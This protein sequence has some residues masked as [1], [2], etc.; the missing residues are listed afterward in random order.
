MADSGA[1]ARLIQSDRRG[2]AAQSGGDE[3][4]RSSAK[5]EA[6]HD[7]FNPHGQFL[8]VQTGYVVGNVWSGRGSCRRRGRTER[9]HRALENAGNVE[10]VFH[11]YHRPSFFWISGEVG[12]R[13]KNRR[14]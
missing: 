8:P 12:F 1:A 4:Y 13:I 2:E 5:D 3:S 11:S 14:C 6:T 9:A 7:D 10:R